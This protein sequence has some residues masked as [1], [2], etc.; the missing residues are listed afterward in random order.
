M[1]DTYGTKGPELFTAGYQP[2]PV[3]GKAPVDKGWSTLPIT[4]DWVQGRASNGAANLSVGV[5]CGQGAV[6]V[7]AADFDF[8]DADVT[9][10][11]LNSFFEHFGEAPIRVGRAPKALAV[12]AGEPGQ[13]K[14]KTS[15]ESPDGQVHT[16]ELLGEGQQF[17]AFGTHPDTKKPY[18]WPK[19]QL[20]ETWELPPLDFEQVLMWMNGVLPTLL[21]EGWVSKAQTTAVAVS[22]DAFENY[23]P[24]LKD[25]DLD[26]VREELLPH[27]DP[28]ASND[29]WVRIGMALHHQGR[30]SGEWLQAWD[31]WS[32][33]SDKYK[34][35]ECEKRWASFHGS[36]LT[37][38]TL[39]KQTGVTVRQ[40]Q[41]STLDV[42]RARIAA[43]TDVFALEAIGTEAAQDRAVTETIRA[44]LEQAMHDRS[45]ELNGNRRLPVA[46]VRGWLTPA[47]GSGGFPDMGENGPLCT[48]DNVEQVLASM[49]ATVRYNVMTKEDEV[50]IPGQSFTVDNFFTASLGTVFSECVRQGLPAN[51]SLI[52]T[53]I[54][55][56]SDRNQYNP[57]LTWIQ[58]KPWDGVSR[59]QALCN[60]LKVAPGKETMRDMVLRKWLLTAV[61]A[62]ALPEGVAAQGLLVLTGPQYKGK[63][64]WVMRLAPDGY[65]KEGFTLDVKDKDLVKQALSSWITELGEVDATFKKSDISALKAFVTKQQDVLR[66]PFAPAESRFARKT[67]FVGTVNDEEY[68]HDPTGNRR[69]WTVEIL[70]VDHNHSIDMQQLWAEM[71]V[72][73]EQGE[74]FWMTREEMERLNDHNLDFTA[75]DSINQRLL[76]ELD[77]G[78]SRETWAWQTATEIA[79]KIGYERPTKADLNRIASTVKGQNGGERRRG[80]GGVKLLLAPVTNS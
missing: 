65:V 57:V 20:P 16:F 64:R 21:P 1:S 53:Y 6:A 18:R 36:S 46:T 44:L 24:P 70:D 50:L 66:K 47:A 49:R 61:A 25:W 67:V 62:A 59:V 45:G 80:H 56:I 72:A 12:Y 60:T 7:Y 48:I 52:K 63:S 28:D 54:N 14:L 13:H 26:R 29:E 22:A 34:D 78:S 71:L 23:K 19:T 11:V 15:F 75:Q 5:R 76:T 30:G 4:R 32:A 40:Q 73:F 37:L 17:V 74:Q 43:A 39:I 55:V 51:T 38:A 35:G 69:F 10:R 8:Y 3:R 31:E 33:Q 42:Y 77:W 79:L 27:L 2:V 41:P 9:K 58:S 68:L